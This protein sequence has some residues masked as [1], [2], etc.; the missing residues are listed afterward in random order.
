VTAVAWSP[1]RVRGTTGAVGA[2]VAGL[3]LFGAL[4]GTVIATGGPAPEDRGPRV[5]DALY[6]LEAAWSATSV[7]LDATIVLGA[8][9]AVA[10]LCVLL[11]VRRWRRAVFWTIAIAGIVLLEPLLKALVARPGIRAAHDEHSFPSGNAMASVAL[12]AAVWL[13]VEPP[14]LDRIRGG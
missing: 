6:E 10:V 2:L 1:E 8:A 4:A 9:A 7:L 3:G 13:V 5:A 11:A 12:V 14:P